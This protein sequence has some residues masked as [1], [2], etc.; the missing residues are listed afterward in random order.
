MKEKEK[1]SQQEETIND[2]LEEALP[3]EEG[4]E[5]RAEEPTVIEEVDEKDD[6]QKEIVKFRRLFGEISPDSIPDA[7]W[8]QVR[9]GQSLCASFALYIYEQAAEMARVREIN[10]KNDKSAPKKI[11]TGGG[12]EYFSPE[13]VRAMDGKTVRKQYEKIMRSMEHWN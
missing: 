3:Q 12:E 11:T 5:E 8:D 9:E 1:K 7:V 13:A 2:K 6:Y 10:D 4:A